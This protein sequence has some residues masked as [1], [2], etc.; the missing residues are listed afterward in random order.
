MVLVGADVAC[1]SERY[2]DLSCQRITLPGGDSVL[3]A[4]HGAHVLSWIVGGVEQFYLSPRAVLDGR[5]AIRGGVPLCFPQFNQRGPLPRHGFARNMPWDL[6]SVEVRG[7]AAHITLA[8]AANAATRVI[9][10]QSF[11]AAF[12]IDLTPG[13]LRLTLSVNNTDSIPLVFSGALHT[14]LAVS[15]IARTQL[16][17]L[18]GQA[19]WD[20]LN[21]VHGVA[22]PVLTFDGEFDRVYAAA[23]HAL[24]LRCGP[25]VLTLEQSETWSHT[26]V[27]NP[28]AERCAQLS[29]LPPDGYA[30]M[31]CVEAAQVTEP[32]TVG[33]GEVWQGWQRL[34]STI[35]TC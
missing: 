13:V 3:V 14:Y 11:I 17:G 26:V 5:T 10:P 29:D 35:E 9:W 27:W 20:A 15:D 32:V 34:V 21:D 6:Q 8:L 18:E 31:L 7:N 4:L 19:Q 1:A 12:N 2:G 33:A 16:M 23:P 25:R 24:T 28:G 30:Q 22:A